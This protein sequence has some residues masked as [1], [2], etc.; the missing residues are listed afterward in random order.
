MGKLIKYVV[1]AAVCI[2]SAFGIYSLVKT[3]KTDENTLE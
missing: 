2:I 1:I 3:A